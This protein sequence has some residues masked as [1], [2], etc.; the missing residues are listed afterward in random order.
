[1]SGLALRD[2]V[3]GGLWGA[4]VGDALGVPVEFRSRAE[5]QRNPVTDLRGHGTHNQP[6]GTWSDD[7]SLMLCTVDSLLRHDFDT[8]DMGQRFVQWSEGKLWTPWGSVFD[9]GGATSRA[10]GRIEQGIP[11]ERAGGTDENSN[12][13]GSLMRI[14]PVAL[15]FARE[16]AE[17]LLEF[18]YRA[19]AITHRHVRS[20]TA[21]GLYCLVAAGLLR[22]ETAV[23]AHQSAAQTV[24]PLFKTM[25]WTAERLCFAAALAP[26]L[27]TLPEQEIASGGHVIDTLT[28]SLW[29][30][31]TSKSYEETVLKAVNLGGDADTTGI[32]AGGLAGVCY[33]RAAVPEHWCNAMA[34]A[35]DLNLLFER[36]A[37][38]CVVE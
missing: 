15:R 29:C 9:I 17:R 27:A 34:R 8:A 31:L 22:G 16:P 1:M 25:P 18:A 6:K 7:S 28:A 2:R 5:V 35:N 23:A 32:A 11:A 37:D 13:N 20:P 19:S 12:G 14:L 3:V 26:H 33:G 30:L 4:V 10:L 36:F 38:V 24:G 21:C